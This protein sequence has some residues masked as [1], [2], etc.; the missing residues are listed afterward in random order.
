MKKYFLSVVL[1]IIVAVGTFTILLYSY[2]KNY[3]NKYVEDMVFECQFS[4]ETQS[5]KNFILPNTFASKFV[6][7]NVPFED[8]VL[9]I[10]IIDSCVKN[11][12]RQSKK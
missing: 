6:K 9:K 4:Y 12:Y 10:K 11:I 8:E 2:N 7:Q 5:L 1:G 3:K